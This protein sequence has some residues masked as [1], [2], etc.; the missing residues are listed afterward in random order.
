MD[1]NNKS[2]MKFNTF[3]NRIPSVDLVLKKAKRSNKI[4]NFEFEDLFWMPFKS[5]IID[6]PQLLNKQ[7]FDELFYYIILHKCKYDED[8]A[9]IFHKKSLHKNKKPTFVEIRREDNY[10]KFAF[11]CWIFDEFDKIN[12]LE[13]AYLSS[14]PNAKL[15]KAGIDEL[16]KL[17]HSVIINL[18]AEKYNYT[19]DEV[20]NLSYDLI[21]RIQLHDKINNEID[22]RYRE[23]IKEE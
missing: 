11:L 1:N 15:K 18:I 16:N 10:K 9:L 19:H 12:R 22:E 5:I 6:I 14:P 4:I 7:Q 23:L 21:F 17:G 2:I 20:L 3:L 13:K 8:N